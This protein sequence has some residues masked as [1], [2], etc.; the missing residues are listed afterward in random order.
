MTPNGTEEKI[1]GHN[2]IPRMKIVSGRFSVNCAVNED[3]KLLQVTVP[4]RPGL[5]G[6]AETAQ[7]SG[8]RS[9]RPV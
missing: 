1:G 3:A 8:Q 4:C 6:P 9:G 7:E 5:H 2:S